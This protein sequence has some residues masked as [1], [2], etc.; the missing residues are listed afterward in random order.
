MRKLTKSY[1]KDF[2]RKLTDS[3]LTESLI[4]DYVMEYPLKNDVPLAAYITLDAMS[5]EALMIGK[6]QSKNNSKQKSKYCTE[7]IREKLSYY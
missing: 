7:E 2:E 4:E 6:K 5:I 3:S 1:E